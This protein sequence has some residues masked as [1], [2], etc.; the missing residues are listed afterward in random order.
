L[1]HLIGKKFYNN[2]D[3]FE[4][5]WKDSERTGQGKK[6]DFFNELLMLTLL[7]YIKIGKYF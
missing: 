6:R 2:G 1:L 3:M 5:E 4:G 7:I